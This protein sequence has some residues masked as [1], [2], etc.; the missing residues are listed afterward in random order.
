[1]FVCEVATNNY[2]IE[3]V[4]HLFLA[5]FTFQCLQELIIVNKI[6]FT[7]A[8]TLPLFYDI[9]EELYYIYE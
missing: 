5:T 2:N 6:E 9:K 4:W 7:I 1:M 3:N 8:Y